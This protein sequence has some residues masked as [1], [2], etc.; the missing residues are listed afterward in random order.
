[1]NNKVL[2]I[3]LSLFLLIWTIIGG[4][5]VCCDWQ[6]VC[7]RLALVSCVLWV[8]LLLSAAGGDMNEQQGKQQGDENTEP[9]GKVES[10][11]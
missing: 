3:V 11:K 9:Y 6:P 4:V 2:W 8:F 7:D 1:M 5:Y 10:E